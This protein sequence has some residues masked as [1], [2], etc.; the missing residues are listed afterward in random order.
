MKHLIVSLFAALFVAVIA[1][2]CSCF[3]KCDKDA[4]DG[5]CVKC[6]QSCKMKCAAGKCDESCKEKCATKCDKACKEKC[7]T[8]CAVQCDKAVKDAKDAAPAVK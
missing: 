1:S 5:C 8:K 3:S 2:G 7:A 4:K 6:E